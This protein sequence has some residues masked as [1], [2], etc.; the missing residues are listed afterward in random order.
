MILKYFIIIVIIMVMVV[1]MFMVMFTLMVMMMATT[2]FMIVFMI[3]MASTLTLFLMT[4]HNQIHKLFNRIRLNWL[5]NNKHI[6][7]NLMN[8]FLSC[9]Y[10]I[11]SYINMRQDNRISS[12]YL[13]IKVFLK[14]LMILL[15]SLNIHNTNMRNY[16]KIFIFFYY[17]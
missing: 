12:L 6:I 2:A 5:I 14:V 9:L 15:A 3:M 8:N 16:S 10:L 13:I 11:I 1:M 17:I 7:M 4:C